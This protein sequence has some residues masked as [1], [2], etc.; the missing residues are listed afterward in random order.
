MTNHYVEDL[1]EMKYGLVENL[2]HL[3][4]R[5]NFSVAPPA[6]PVLFSNIRNNTSHNHLSKEMKTLSDEAAELLKS[7]PDFMSFLKEIDG[8][9]FNGIILYNFSNTEPSL[10]NFFII[11][12][13]YRHNDDFINPDLAERLVLGEDGTSVFTYDIQKHLFEIRDRIWTENIYSS[14]DNFYYFLNKI[15][16]TVS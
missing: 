12:D 3:M 14:H 13:F 16:E 1:K 10:Q 8:F 15:I 11:N 9:E 2:Q 4:A 6:D 7:H 5:F